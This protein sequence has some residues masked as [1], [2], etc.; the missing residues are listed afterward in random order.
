MLLLW[1]FASPFLSKVGKT[2]QTRMKLV[3]FRYV[4]AGGLILLASHLVCNPIAVSHI[5]I[6]FAVYNNAIMAQ[7]LLI[8]L[9]AI[10][11]IAGNVH[12]STRMLAAL[13]GPLSEA[14]AVKLSAKMRFVSKMLNVACAGVVGIALVDS[15]LYKGYNGPH[16]LRFVVWF[17]W[18]SSF[19][20]FNF[21][22]LFFVVMGEEWNSSKSAERTAA[23]S[24]KGGP[25]AVLSGNENPISAL[26]EG[27]PRATL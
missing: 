21:G 23:R 3:L 4:V 1:M 22:L 8:A 12:F 16:P 20:M 7:L 24:S 9:Y 10:L 2:L 15:L 14:W 11:L 18:V 26:S 17:L 19:W 13:A 25:V 27:A 5:D 6:S